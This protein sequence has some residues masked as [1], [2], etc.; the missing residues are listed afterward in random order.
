[1]SEKKRRRRRAQQADRAAA[2]ASQKI[3]PP[4]GPESLRK[5]RRALRWVAAAVVLLL[6][7]AAVGLWFFNRAEPAA[8]AAPPAPLAMPPLAQLTYVGAPVCGQCHAREYQLWQGSDHELAMQH[9]TDASVA[10]DFNDAKF[11]Y[12][13]VTSTFFRRDGKFFVN[14]DGPDGALR[15]YEIKYTFGVRP[16]QQYLVEFADG[17]VQALSIAWDTRPRE[18]GGQRWYHLY[19]G[20]HIDHND[21]LHWT[22]LHQNWNYMCAECHTTNLKR[23]YDAAS[24]TFHT[25]FSEIN[26]ACE[27]CHGPGSE[28]TARARNKTLAAGDGLAVHFPARAAWILNPATGN[29]HRALPRSADTELE[30]CGLCHSRRAEIKEG[31]IAGQPLLDT[32]LVSLLTEGL[33]YADGQMHDEVFNYG[34]FLQSKMYAMGVSCGDCHEPHSLKLRAP[35]NGVCLQCHAA[36]KYD[37]P[38]HHHH[39]AGSTGARCAACHMPVHTY[40]GVDRRHDH[41]FRVPRPDQSQQFGTPN[42]CTDCHTDKSAPWAAQAI[43]RWFGP[44]REG[45]QHYAPALHAARA[46]QT[47]APQ[48]LLQVIADHGQPDIARATAYAELAPYLTPAL[49][50]DLQRGI[51]DPNPLVRLGALRGAADVPVEQRWALAA[52]LLRD[53]RRAL[54]IEAAAFLAPIPQQALDAG[55]RNTLQAAL[56]EYIAAQHSNADRPEAHMNLGLLF[57]QRGDAA[58]AE[59]EY[60]TA[61]KL[62]PLFVQGYINLA[63]LYRD[64]DRDGDGEQ[65]L[66]RA[67]AV[68]PENG[69]V[70][71]ALGLLLVR[72]QQLDAATGELARAAQLDPA[73]A[74]Y[75]YVYGVALHTGGRVDKALRVLQS[76]HKRHPADR[77]ILVAL[78]SFNERA[79]HHRAALDY[80]RQLAALAPGDTAAQQMVERLQ[81]KSR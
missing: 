44:Q 54:R 39:A 67:L 61:L 1:M 24:D 58:A 14:T 18:Q 42:A 35:G 79:G 74:R 28:H 22:R 41:S 66:R 56:D 69:A 26:V 50:A 73:Q 81:R 80:A 43:E 68:A 6:A 57:A 11:R 20:Q 7:G 47:D 21:A 3:P 46:Q 17:R 30:T 40:M 12:D 77:D 72:R 49:I 36:A 48:L 65:L 33:Y 70:H 5:P 13:G 63:D 62:D 60:H 9:A 75:V 29:S 76:G 51:G 34:S 45:L 8:T 10:G 2:G 64:L 59:Q 4:A 25:T 19:P 53:P 32:H 31:H 23:G 55:Q 16:L 15:D 52:P 37:A 27:A 78:V 71:Y 38:A